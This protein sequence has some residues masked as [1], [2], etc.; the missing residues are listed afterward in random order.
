MSCLTSSWSSSFLLPHHVTRPHPTSRHLQSWP[1]VNIIFHYWK[2]N[3][4]GK[5]PSSAAL[6]WI[7]KRL[8]LCS[9]FIDWSISWRQTCT[10][11]VE[12]PEGEKVWRAEERAQDVSSS[13]LHGLRA[14][15][16]Q[17]NETVIPSSF[18]TLL[19]S[20]NVTGHIHSQLIWGWKMYV[21]ELFS[22]VTCEEAEH[23]IIS[24]SVRPPVYG[25]IHMLYKPILCN[26]N[27][28]SAFDPS[29]I[30]QLHYG[31]QEQLRGFG[32]LQQTFCITDGWCGV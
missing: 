14:A 5:Q 25:F 28:S 20:F 19:T 11:N 15:A 24:L 4:L 21:G 16:A 17:H 30:E 6:R 3:E 18:K 12:T 26:S 13:S 22:T 27:V 8:Q 23:L 7:T 29:S 10:W 2:N 32:D 1:D 9:V 31:A